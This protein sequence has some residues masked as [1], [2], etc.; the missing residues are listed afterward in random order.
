MKSIQAAQLGFSS[1]QAEKAA[2]FAEILHR[3]NELQ[4]LT[5]ILGAEEFVEG[6][7]RD[8]LELLKLSALSNRVLDIGTGSG[9]PGL[10]SSA[11]S[12]ESE[13]I[14]FL[15]DSEKGKAEYLD[16]AKN[17]LGLRRVSVFHKRAEEVIDLVRAETI[18]ARAVGTVDKI[19]AWIWNCSTWNTLILFKSRGWEK[20]WEEARLTKFGKK[21]TI[22][23]THDYSSGDKTRLLITLK[24]K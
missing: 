23:H 3:E 11:L 10:L 9:V 6:H 13:R 18:T 12:T 22:T 15:T 17:E 4:N 7:L 16:R 1:T 8:S 20:E 21:L 14:W 24:R 19:A 5:R 2:Q